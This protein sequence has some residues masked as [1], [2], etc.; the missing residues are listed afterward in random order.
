MF[1]LVSVK[2]EMR[3]PA[4]SKIFFGDLDSFAGRIES[5]G[6]DLARGLPIEDPILFD[7]SFYYPR[8]A[9]I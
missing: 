7:I 8:E 4:I 3:V 2:I 9:K 1:L 5:V 6:P